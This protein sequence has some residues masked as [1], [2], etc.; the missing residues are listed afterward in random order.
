MFHCRLVKSI[1]SWMT[2]IQWL[3]RKQEEKKRMGPSSTI[4]QGHI[5]SRVCTSK[6]TQ[7]Y[8]LNIDSMCAIGCGWKPCVWSQ[9]VDGSRG[10]HPGSLV[11]PTVLRPLVI[12]F[13][14][15]DDVVRWPSTDLRHLE[16]GIENNALFGRRWSGIRKTCSS[17]RSCDRLIV[18]SREC[19][20]LEPNVSLWTYVFRIRSFHRYQRNIRKQRVRE[21]RISSARQL[22]YGFHCHAS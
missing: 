12:R 2:I 3:R 9:S 14:S 21:N 15:F 5:H 7:T 18:P 19:F 17:H 1:I 16:G 20:I 4:L 11:E 6:F 8:R 10:S 13:T 22:P